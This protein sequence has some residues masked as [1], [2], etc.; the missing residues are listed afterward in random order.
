MRK[1]AAVGIVLLVLGAGLAVGFWPLTSVSGARLA[2]SRASDGTYTGYALGSRITIR[3]KVVDVQYLGFFGT[4]TV[5]L[6][7]GDPN[8]ATGVVVR[9]DARPVAPIGSY[10]YMSAVLEVFVG[11]YWE[12]ATPGDIHAS[13][14]I[15]AAFYGLAGVGLVLLVVALLR[16]PAPP[17]PR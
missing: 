10:V 1:L 13:L 15:D 9:G 16:R 2:A 12:V 3:E 14:P 4:S 7:D 11:Q 6:E 5:E 8:S 17:K